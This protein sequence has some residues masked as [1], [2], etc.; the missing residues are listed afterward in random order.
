M[1]PASADR[2]QSGSSAYHDGSREPATE[3]AELTRAKAYPY[4]VPKSSYAFAFGRALSLVS[5]DPD[6]LLDSV[7]SDGP[8]QSTLREL[9]DRHNV[10]IS[11]EDELFEPLLAYGSNAS[12]EGLSRKFAGR[13]ELPLVL[14]IKATLYDF[15]VV[16]S[17]HIAAYGAIP[18]GLQYCPE[19]RAPVHVLFAN[20][21]QRRMLRATEPNYILAVLDH[22]DLR[23]EH[24]PPLSRV[25]A[26]LS[27]HGLLTIDGI[28]VGVAASKTRDRRFPSL[29]EEEVLDAV[30]D[31]VAPGL[32]IDAFILQN[33]RDPGLSHRRTETIK[34]TARDF[35]YRSWQELDG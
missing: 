10:L 30:R 19:A 5:L 6:R 35:C 4:D 20:P 25:T 12:I 18:A 27:R 7:V 31:I 16:Y 11:P 3:A 28:E 13:P 15:D 24:G 34:M 21:S 2:W 29:T 1:E 17:A 23:S 32:G 22:L 8:D 33:I 26:L 14:A 9:A